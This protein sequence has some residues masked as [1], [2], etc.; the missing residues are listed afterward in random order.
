HPLQ[1]VAD[2][3]V[4]PTVVEPADRSGAPSAHVLRQI[5]RDL[6]VEDGGL[7]IACYPCGSQSCRHHSID[8]R[9]GDPGQRLKAVPINCK[10]WC[11]LLVALTHSAL[12]NLE[13][14]ADFL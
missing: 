12:R 3:R 11:L 7:R 13:I 14:W 6:A 9:Q 5:H 8:L 4:V 10:H 1:G 2:R